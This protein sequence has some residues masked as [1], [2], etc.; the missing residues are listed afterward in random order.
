MTA[1][2][3]TVNATG[4]AGATCGAASPAGAQAIAA[5]GQVQFTYACTVTAGATVPGS[6][7]FKTTPTAGG[8]AGA[9]V[10][11]TSNSVLVTPPLTFQ[12]TVNNPATVSRS[13]Q[14]GQ[15]GDGS[16]NLAPTD[17]NETHDDDPQRVDRRLRLVG[18]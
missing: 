4:G 7:T 14:R 17:S 12:V 2:A 3:L 11:A 15:I 10:E 16:G 6:V 18:R 13:R 8:G 1:T 9:F 5:N